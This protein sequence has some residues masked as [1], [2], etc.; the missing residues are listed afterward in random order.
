MYSKKS[1]ETRGKMEHDC[2]APMR[3][4]AGDGFDNLMKVSQVSKKRKVNHHFAQE[5]T[6]CQKMKEELKLA[7]KKSAAKPNDQQIVERLEKAK[8]VRSSIE[9]NTK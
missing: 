3:Q 9:P 2:I 4:W 5:L 6:K 7:E 1:A 8:K